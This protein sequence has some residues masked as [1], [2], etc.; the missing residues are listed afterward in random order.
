MKKFSYLM[1]GALVVATIPCLSLYFRTKELDMLDQLISEKND[2]LKYLESLAK[3]EH[4]KVLFDDTEMLSATLVWLDALNGTDYI[5]DLIDFPLEDDTVATEETDCDD[6]DFPN[7]S[8]FYELTYDDVWALSI[9]LDN[10]IEKKRLA[11]Q[12]V[13]EAIYDAPICVLDVNLENCLG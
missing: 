5:R 7:E 6:V 12:I 8:D 10:D 4:L 9:T 2:D 1:I 11:Y 3:D 13:K